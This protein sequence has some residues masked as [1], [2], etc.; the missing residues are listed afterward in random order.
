MQALERLLARLDSIP[1][2]RVAHLPT[3]LERAER[4]SQ[5]RNVDIYIKRDDCTGLAIGGNKA[6]KLEFSVGD[7]LDAGATA[8]LTSGGLQSNHVRQTGAIAARFGLECYAALYQPEGA[9]GDAYE[10]SGNFLLDD[11]LGIKSSVVG[12]DDVKEKLL[13]LQTSIRSRGGTP[14]TIPVGAS[15]DVGALGYVLCAAELAIQFR[16]LGIEPSH[17][18]VSTGSAGTQAGLVAGFAVLGMSTSVIGVAV[19]ED[20][21]KKEKAVFRLVVELLA[22]LGLGSTVGE[23]RI[24]VL[25]DWVGAG[26]GRCTTKSTE[27]ITLVARKE[28]ILLDPVYT[29]KGMAGMLDCIRASSVGRVIDPVF[30]HTGGTPALFAYL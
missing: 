8:L 24:T 17:V 29:G 30:V 18:F 1:R 19:S 23:D 4:L 22:R 28:G 27:A 7:A 16:E 10:A 15:D 5:G 25:D 13:G 26:Y 9:G 3:P 14:Y 2:A 6:R 20:R 11:L 12:E 21:Q